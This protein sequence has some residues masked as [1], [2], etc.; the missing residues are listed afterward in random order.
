MKRFL[1]IAFLLLSIYNAYSLDYSLSALRLN[2]FGTVATSKNII[3]FGNYGKYAMTTDKGESWKI[4]SIGET[5][6]IRKIVCDNDTLWGVIGKGEI[7][8]SIDHGFNWER[9]KLSSNQKEE[10]FSLII[11]DNSIYIKTS[12][13][14][15]KYDKSLNMIAKF[16]NED[17]KSTLKEE[18]YHDNEPLEES[19]VAYNDIFYV[20]HSIVFTNYYSDFIIIDKNLS[21]FRKINLDTML[22]WKKIA[23]ADLSAKYNVSGK[24]VLNISGNLYT[25]NNE[26]SKFEYFFPDT[27]FLNAYNGNYYKDGLLLNYFFIN[28]ELFA[29]RRRISTD[30][31]LIDF[32]KKGTCFNV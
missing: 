17:T 14:I 31:L 16:S 5:E 18:D 11:A 3:A 27:S 7:I 22:Y 25:C 26:F 2:Y 6:N 8:R 23:N 12:L 15:Y 21:N 4:Y 20:N 13:S 10:Y 19:K 32:K 9:F 28:N 30:S 29:F 1:I 24:Q